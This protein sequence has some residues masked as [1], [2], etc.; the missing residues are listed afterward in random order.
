MP[1]TPRDSEHWQARRRHWRGL[2]L[3]EVAP[4]VALI[5]IA[6]VVVILVAIALR[7]A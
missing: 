1:R 5:V 2:T 3:R 7:Q 6:I 4:A